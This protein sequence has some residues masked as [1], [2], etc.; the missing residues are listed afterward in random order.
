MFLLIFLAMEELHWVSMYAR[1]ICKS[2]S[3]ILHELMAIRLPRFTIRLYVLL[4]CG[5]ILPKVKTRLSFAVC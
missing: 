4:Y 1:M 5:L 3:S 2:D